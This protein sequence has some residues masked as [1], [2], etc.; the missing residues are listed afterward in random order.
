MASFMADA[1]FFMIGCVCLAAAFIVV[2][3]GI[4][5]LVAIAKLKK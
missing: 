1:F 5:T 3:L 4:Y 2:A